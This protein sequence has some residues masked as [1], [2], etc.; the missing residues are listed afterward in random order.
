MYLHNHSSVWLNSWLRRGSMS[1]ACSQPPIHDVSTTS[2]WDIVGFIVLGEDVILVCIPITIH[3]FGSILGSE[4]GPHP[5]L[6][7]H[8][9]LITS[10]QD[11]V[12]FHCTGRGW[13]LVHIFITTHPFDS[14]IC[15]EEVTHPT[16]ALDPLFMMI[17]LLD[18][19]SFHHTVGGGQHFV[20]A[21]YT[22]DF[23]FFSG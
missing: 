16:L 11:T 1:Y 20:A 10:Y 9:N 3:L 12:G 13:H 4:G 21:R 5:M 2:Y 7:V 8:D 14:I 6:P 17:Q 18:I 15:S 19:I 23:C 22:L